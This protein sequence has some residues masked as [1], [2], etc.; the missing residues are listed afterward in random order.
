M[1]ADAGLL[2]RAVA[3]V[4]ENALRYT[5]VGQVV[6]I[7]AGQHGEHTELRV[8]DRGPGVARDA[9]AAVF[10]AFQRRDDQ[11]VS[12]GAGVGLGLAIARG[13]LRAMHGAIS[14]EDTPGGGLTVILAVPTATAGRQRQPTGAG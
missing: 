12:T 3:N 10:E 4:V 14:L 6:R 2:E 7:T 5:P 13:F 8:I 1:T 9:R 11:A